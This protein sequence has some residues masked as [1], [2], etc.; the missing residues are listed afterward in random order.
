MY[1]LS[2]IM[3]TK[4]KSLPITTENKQYNARYKM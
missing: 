1:F 4:F 3:M 2:W